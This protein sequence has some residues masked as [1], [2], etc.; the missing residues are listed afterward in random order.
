MLFPHQNVEAEMFQGE[1]Q[2]F[3]GVCDRLNRIAS[4]ENKCIADSAIKTLKYFKGV[5]VRAKICANIADVARSQA[6]YDGAVFDIA[7]FIEDTA[8]S[9]SDNYKQTGCTDRGFWHLFTEI[10]VWADLSMWERSSDLKR[11]AT[12]T[13]PP[14]ASLGDIQPAPTAVPAAIPTP[15]KKL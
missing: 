1:N 12:V 13:L 9:Y 6:C 14:F 10:D 15:P 8:K 2:D 4:G 5:N 11:F 7:K 3:A